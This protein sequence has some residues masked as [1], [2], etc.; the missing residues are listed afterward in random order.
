[1]DDNLK[2]LQLNERNTHTEEKFMERGGEATKVSA[3]P[4]DAP[5]L[6]QVESTP[7]ERS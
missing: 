6:K 3:S 2:L 1:M 5:Q 7:R 4:T